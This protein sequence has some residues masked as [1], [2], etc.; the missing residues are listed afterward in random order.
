MIRYARRSAVSSQKFTLAVTDAAG[1]IE[2]THQEIVPRKGAL[3]LQRILGTE[4]TIEDAV[5]AHS[6]PPWRDSSVGR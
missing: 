5:D 2:T 4:G 1:S 3:E 6:R